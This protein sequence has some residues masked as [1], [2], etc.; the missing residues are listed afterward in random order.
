[1]PNSFATSKQL[2]RVERLRH[3]C[4]IFPNRI[5]GHFS[6]KIRRP[7]EQIVPPPLGFEL[8]QNPCSDGILLSFRQPSEFA[9]RLLEYLAH[10]E[11]LI[12]IA[13]TTLSER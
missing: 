9:Q 5:I 8:G 1:M 10:A 6:Q 3:A 7:G 12:P 11:I 4:F 2:F 13:P